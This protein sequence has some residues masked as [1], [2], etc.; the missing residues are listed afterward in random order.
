M[1]R[2]RI[3]VPID[4]QRQSDLALEY[5]GII[6]SKLDA[7][8]SCIH[9]MEDKGFLVKKKSE[10]QTKHTLRREAENKLS[11][12]VN[13]IL[14]YEENIP[15]EIIITSGNVYQKVLEK[16][17]DL[18]AQIIIMGRSSASP[19]KAAGIGSNARKI[20]A[21][22]TIPV[23]TATNQKIAKEKHLILPLDLSRSCNEPLHWAI[24]SALLLDASVS[25]ISVI[26]K[27]QS[28][29]RPVYLKKLE[30]ARCIFAER[31][32]EC[33]PHLLENR[34]TTPR[35]IVSFSERTENG[36]ILLMTC[37]K[38]EASGTYPGSIAGEV[39]ARTA[40]PVLYIQSRNKFGLSM[41]RS[42]RYFQAIY[43]LKVPIQ[44]P[45]I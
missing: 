35:E 13:S 21:N 7:M 25:V 22:S 45:L 41:D 34:S 16:S 4:F 3:L 18:H 42:S 32:I 36:I 43:P 19:E 31:N 24:E 10:E 39:I 1:A 15:F 27:E 29:L 17:I 5:A 14:K 28:D 23:I 26:D 38:K 44:D 9:V 30:E 40:A 11:E 37:Y 20:I 6:A 33:S 2:S 8:I 12:R